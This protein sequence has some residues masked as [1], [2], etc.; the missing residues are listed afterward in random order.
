MSLETSVTQQKK[1][2]VTGSLVLGALLPYRQIYIKST[3]QWPTKRVL[4]DLSCMR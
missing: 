4:H 3:L 2:S 1:G